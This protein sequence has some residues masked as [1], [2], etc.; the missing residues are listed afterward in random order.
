[1]YLYFWRGCNDKGRVFNGKRWAENKNEVAEF[2]RAQHGY[3]LKIARAKSQDNGNKFRK[4]H[5][6]DKQKGLFFGRLAALLASGIPLLRGLE[7]IGERAPKNLRHVCWLLQVE[8]EKGMAFSAGLRKQAHEFSHLAV[9]VAEAGETSGKL[10]L[11]LQEL[12]GYYLKERETKRFLFNACL[13]P[14]LVLCL[15]FGTMSYFIYEVL[16]VFGQVYL[17]LGIEVNAFLLWIIEQVKNLKTSPEILFFIVST[18]VFAVW[19]RRKKLP[20][21]FLKLPLVRNYYAIFL[22]IRCC[23]LLGLLLTSGIT[24]PQALHLLEG[25]LP[26]GRLRF[27]NQ[28]IIRDILKGCSLEEATAIHSGI[29]GNV[30]REFIA[31][32]ENGGTL[33]KM[34]GEAASIL[35]GDLE[36]G[37]KDCKVMLEPVLLL[38]LAIFV[39]SGFCFLLAPLYDLLSK[40]TET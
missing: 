2:V 22:E 30:S 32:G 4:S 20:V 36:A 28:Q 18:V 27:T 25:T 39:G 40:F 6:T 38:F 5:L 3:V 16:P 31:I 15:T 26:Q 7:L 13:Y 37:L 8:I 10:S 33:D 34:L 35:E 19:Y 23:R 12:S 29:F 21:F 1:M 9:Q 11:L 17:A 24:L 14:G